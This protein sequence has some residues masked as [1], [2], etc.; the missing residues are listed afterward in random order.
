MNSQV[1]GHNVHCTVIRSRTTVRRWRILI[2]DSLNARFQV[3]VPFELKN[4]VM[5]LLY[6]SKSFIHDCDT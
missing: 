5:I 6:H 3:Y 1:S 4:P 2:V